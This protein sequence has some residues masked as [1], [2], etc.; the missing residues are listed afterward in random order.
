[1]QITDLLHAQPTKLAPAHRTSYVVTRTIVHFDNQS[2]TF[3]TLLYFFLAPIAISIVHRLNSADT[4]PILIDT[5]RRRLTCVRIG[6]LQLVSRFL[7]AASSHV[8][9][10]CQYCLQW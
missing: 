5:V 1:M 8:R 3:W 4:R 9:F 2:L 6:S 10:G 7:S